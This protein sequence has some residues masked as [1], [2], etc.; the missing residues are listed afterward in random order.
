MYGIEKV[1]L[2]TSSMAYSGGTPVATPQQVGG[3]DGRDTPL[4]ST[5]LGGLRSLDNPKYFSIEAASELARS[6]RRAH[7]VLHVRKTYHCSFI[8][9]YI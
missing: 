8:Y 6:G 4:K 7:Q 1:S 3:A 2:F 5:P 9:I